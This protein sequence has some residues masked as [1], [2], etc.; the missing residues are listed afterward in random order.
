[1]RQ[2]GYTPESMINLKAAIDQT[3]S[4]RPV[5]SQKSAEDCRLKFL[6]LIDAPQALADKAVH[7]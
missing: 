1:M 2:I 3:N 7:K 6:S 5:P 4:E